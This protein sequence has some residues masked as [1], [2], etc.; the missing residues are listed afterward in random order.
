MGDLNLDDL[1]VVHVTSGMVTS[2]ARFFENSSCNEIFQHEFY[3]F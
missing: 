2:L 1:V 3:S